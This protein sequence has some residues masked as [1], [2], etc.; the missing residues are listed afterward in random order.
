MVGCDMSKSDPT[1]RPRFRRVDAEE[2][3]RR[4]RLPDPP[5]LLDVRRGAAFEQQPGIPAAVPFAL[6]RDPMLIPDVARGRPVVAYC[7]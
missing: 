6:D 3:E 2:L 5:L 1:P 4:L 7:L